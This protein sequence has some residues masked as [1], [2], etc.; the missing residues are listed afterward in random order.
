MSNNNSD[1]QRFTISN[2][3]QS[4]VSVQERRKLDP[5]WVSSRPILGQLTHGWITSRFFLE[6]NEKKNKNKK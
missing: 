2:L 6:K 4:F 1:E 5:M 3:D